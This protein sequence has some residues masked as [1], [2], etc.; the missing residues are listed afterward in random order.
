MKVIKFYD[1]C[2][3]ICGNWYGTTFQPPKTNSKK[4]AVEQMKKNGWKQN[5]GLTL[6]EKC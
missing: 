2:C 4:E 3:D 5:A 6:C 1:T